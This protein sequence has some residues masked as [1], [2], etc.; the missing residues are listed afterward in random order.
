[1]RTHLY[2]CRVINFVAEKKIQGHVNVRAGGVCTALLQHTRANDAHTS[3]VHKT[4]SF[5]L[6]FKF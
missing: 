5:F 2:T 1:M 6:N 3:R 4:N